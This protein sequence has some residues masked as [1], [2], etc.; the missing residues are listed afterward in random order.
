MK[1]SRPIYS[2]RN[3]EKGCKECGTALLGALFCVMLVAFAAAAMYTLFGQELF[4]N[5]L[6]EERIKAQ[7][8][9]TGAAARAL[10]YA[11]ADTDYLVSP[12][13]EMTSGSLG[14]GAYS[15][16]IAVLGDAYYMIRATGTVGNSSQQVKVYTRSPYD[17]R[18]FRQAIF[19]NGKVKMSGGGNVNTHLES[20]SHS[21]EDTSVSGHVQ[22]LGDANSVGATTVKGK[23]SVG[24]VVRSGAPRI[25]FPR[26]DF[27]YYYNIAKANGEVHVGNVN[28]KGDYSPSG[29]VMWV[30]GDVKISSHTAIDGALFATGDVHQAGHCT[31][32]QEGT[33]PA[34]V[35]RD[36]NIFLSG[37]SKS[38]TGIV[39][40][41]SGQVDVSGA[42]AIT[43]MII[44]WGDVITRGSWGVMDYKG[45]KPEL[46]D[47]A[48]LEILAW[49]M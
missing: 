44:A 43:G 41:A 14:S 42:H 34:I 36:G 47:E 27:D 32:N 38:M 40:A 37:Q 16:E 24:G 35:S 29:G 8:V 3:S 30:I 7:E 10:A 17:P 28:L 1:T 33:L 5:R 11:A 23:A 9:A 25:K 46:D 15:V 19:A 12:P 4:T 45:D 39:Y 20:G 26:L 49:E 22:I 21:N 31:I 13:S 48:R 6:I 2:I 18:A